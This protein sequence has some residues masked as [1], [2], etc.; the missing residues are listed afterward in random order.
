MIEKDIVSA[1]IFIKL[2][3]TGHLYEAVQDTYP[4]ITIEPSPCH[5]PQFIDSST[6]K[7]PLYTTLSDTDKSESTPCFLFDFFCCCT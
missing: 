7:Q 4:Q 3:D 6:E 5:Y 1:P 2:L